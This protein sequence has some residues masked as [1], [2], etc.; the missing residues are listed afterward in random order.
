MERLLFLIL[1]KC[2]DVADYVTKFRSIVTQLKSSSTKFQIDKNL[3]IFLFQYNLSAIHFAYCQSYAQKYEHFGPDGSVKY[4]FFV[5][6][7]I[8]F[9]I[10]LQIFQK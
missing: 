1:N 4:T 3:L 6:Q 2:K 5:T 10:R 7:Y 8:I 9:R